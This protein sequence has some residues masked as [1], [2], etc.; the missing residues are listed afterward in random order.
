MQAEYERS[1]SYF[2]FQELNNECI[3]P[4][5][6]KNQKKEEEVEEEKYE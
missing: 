2:Y 4:S 1:S 3:T 6:I 5:E